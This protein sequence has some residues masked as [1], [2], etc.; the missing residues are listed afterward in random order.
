MQ[1]TNKKSSDLVPA[2]ESEASHIKKWSYTSL[3]EV[4]LWLNSLIIWNVSFTYPNDKLF[5]G[6]ADHG[7][8]SVIGVPV[9]AQ[10]AGE[11]GGE[12]DN[13]EEGRVRCRIVL[14]QDHTRYH[15]QQE[16]QAAGESFRFMLW[17]LR[18]NKMGL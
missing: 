5:V 12:A 9:H 7:P 16:D 13:R 14:K 1:Q 10:Q 17:S 6:G 15:H 2:A 11:G 3:S 18:K 4:K 8:N